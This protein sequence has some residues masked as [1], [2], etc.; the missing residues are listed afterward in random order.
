MRKILLLVAALVV[1]SGLA[2]PV[3]GHAYLD[4]STPE[5]GG[6]V[7][8]VPQDV[9]LSFSGDGIQ[10]ATVDVV[11]PTGDD[12]SGEAAIDD[13]NR[14]QVTVPVDS[15]AEGVYIV[16]WEVLADDGHTTSG[17]F[18]F[19]VGDEQV[20]REMVLDTLEDDVEDDIAW[21][22]AVSNGGILLAVAGLLGIPL[23]FRLA[24]RP[25]LSGE[26][27]TDRTHRASQRIRQHSTVVCFGLS[28]LLLCSLLVAA[29]VQIQAF[30]T[31]SVETLQ[32]FL[33]SWLGGVWIVQ[34]LAVCGLLV[35]LVTA[36]RTGTQRVDPLVGTAVFAFVV[37]AG[38]A[39]TSHSA[40]A[41][42]RLLGGAIGGIHIL[43][44]GLWLG[45]LLLLAILMAVFKQQFP[46]PTRNRLT[47]AIV[48]RYSVL[49]VAGVS[50][51]AST[52]L[53]FGSWHVGETGGLFET[54]YGLLLG[55]KLLLVLF[56]LVIGGYHHFIVLPRLESQPSVISRVFG[57]RVE[58]DG[59]SSK[60]FGLFSNTLRFELCVLV[61]VVLLSGVVT[62]SAPAA[63]VLDGDTATSQQIETSFDDESGITAILDITPVADDDHD[64]GNPAIESQQPV[65][66]DLSFERDGRMLQSDDGVELRARSLEDGTTV[67]VDLEATDGRYSTVMTLPRAGDWELRFVGDPDGVF[68]TVE[69]NVVVLDGDEESAESTDDDHAGGGHDHDAGDDHSSGHDHHSGHDHGSAGFTDNPLEVGGIVFGIYGLLAVGYQINAL[70]RRPTVSGSETNEPGEPKRE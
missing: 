65:V 59:G 46:A 38:V 64:S 5:N 70:G 39:V 2:T 53:F 8:V 17:S 44:A 21:L 62:A 31:L 67:S 1:L 18:F 34:L 36:I 26:T 52:G 15:D 63:V 48:R 13:E 40:T 7:D 54:T 51:L 66:F 12:K 41:A 60:Q 56:A 47:G 3:A 14:Q 11:G 22:E 9:E 68:G 27:R 23:T 6:Q 37:T 4:S 29:V 32:P 33:S 50:M 30:G 28:I 16:E 43:G 69:Q 24:V 55:A 35:L 57:T 58:T 25:V 10:H 19:V 20:D 45:G 49:A 42:G 61:G